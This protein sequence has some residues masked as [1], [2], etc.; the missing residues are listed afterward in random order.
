MATNERVVIRAGLGPVVDWEQPE[1]T[2]A[3]VYRLPRSVKQWKPTPEERDLRNRINRASE[4]LTEAEEAAYESLVDE[5]RREK[6]V[7]AVRAWMDVVAEDIELP[8]NTMVLAARMWDQVRAVRPNMD[9]SEYHIAAVGAMYRASCVCGHPEY[10]LESKITVLEEFKWFFGGRIHKDGIEAASKMVGQCVHAAES[11][12]DDETPPPV[13]ETRAEVGMLREEARAHAMAALTFLGKG[14]GC[15]G[16]VIDAAKDLFG[17]YIDKA[18]KVPPAWKRY[19]Q[20]AL[21][22]CSER[23]NRERL[24]TSIEPRNPGIKQVAKFV[25]CET[26]D[27]RDAA[28]DLRKAMGMPTAGEEEEGMVVSQD[29]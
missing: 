7:G 29:A 19:E 5:S 15:S 1:E 26:E 17:R 13:M 11:T 6:V 2:E 22:I 18:G 21:V 16:T 23:A 9:P 8:D 20:A 4:A 25:G 28:W 10:L 14:A 24:S 27:I 12:R 3:V